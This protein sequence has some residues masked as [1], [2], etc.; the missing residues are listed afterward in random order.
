MVENLAAENQVLRARLEEAQETLDA[1]RRGEVDG[2]VVSTPKGEQVYT[3]TG[4]EKPYRALIEDMREGAVMLS[5]DNTVLY[6]NSGFAK[7]VKRPFEKIVGTNIE[8][9]ISQIYITPLRELVSLARSGKGAI[10]KEITLEA[11]DNI[12]VPALVSVNSMLSDT[13]NNTF[14]VVTNLTEHMEA[15]VQQY[16]KNLEDLVAERTKQLKESERFSAIGQTAAM[17]GHDIR[18][19]LQSITSELYLAKLELPAI[20]ESEVRNNLAESIA[21]ID[22]DVSYISKI[23]H[24][25]QDFSRPINPVIR[26]TDL[27]ALCEDVLLKSDNPENVRASCKIEKEVARVLTDPDALKRALENL[28]TNAFQAMAGGDNKMSEPPVKSKKK[29]PEY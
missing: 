10:T 1:I 29:L 15:E 16:T 12:S 21:N 20:A 28:T 26:E 9:M 24:D 5:E 13:L 11:S 14:L 19:P 23:I 25:L 8:N 27:Q 6:C 7:M 17:V 3:I 4:A 2:L 18:N 22:K